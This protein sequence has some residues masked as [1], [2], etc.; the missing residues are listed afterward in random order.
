MVINY[1]RLSD[2]TITD[3]YDIPN[4]NKLINRI[5]NC[6]IYSKF[7]CQLGFWQV[8]MHPESVEWTAFSCPFGHF[9]W[10]VMLFGLKN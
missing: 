5:Q 6:R 10:L 2:N 9:E 1:K 7:D 3:S 8:K 4:K